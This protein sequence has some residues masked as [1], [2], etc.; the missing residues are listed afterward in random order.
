MEEFEIYPYRRVNIPPEP[1][2]G[3]AKKRHIPRIVLSKPQI[4]FWTG[5]PTILNNQKPWLMILAFVF[6][7]AL[8]LGELNPFIGPMVALIAYQCA[9]ALPGVI[10][11]ALASSFYNYH[12]VATWAG[13]VALPVIAVLI[14]LFRLNAQNHRWILPGLIFAIN[15]IAKSSIIAWLEP[16]YYNFMVVLIESLLGA[17]VVVLMTRAVPALS[18]VV[19]MRRLNFEEMACLA[20]MVGGILTG[21]NQLSWWQLSLQ[22]IV[23][24]WL[25]LMAA[26]LY[27]FGGGA[28]TGTLVGLIPSLATLAPPLL[29]GVYAFGGLMAGSCKS[30]G[31]MGVLLGFTLGNLI[32]T[33]Y[34]V[35]PNSWVGFFGETALALALFMIIPAKY[36]VSVDKYKVALA[37][38]EPGADYQEQNTSNM[39]TRFSEVFE[40]LAQTFEE[41]ATEKQVAEG[42]YWYDMMRDVGEKACAE[43]SRFQTCWERDFQRTSKYLMDCISWIELNGNISSAQLNEEFKKRCHRPREVAVAVN[44]LFATKRAHR[45]WQRDVMESREILTGQLKGLSSVMDNLAEAIVMERWRSNFQA[46]PYTIKVG[47]AKVGK[48]GSHISGDSFNTLW[49]PDG[50]AAIILSDGMGAGPEAAKE[51]SATV[52]LLS[53]LL[54][55]GMNKELAVR[56]VNSLLVMGAKD[57]T[58]AT[59][60]LVIVD[61]NSALAEFVKIGA[62]ASFIKRGSKIGIIK[63][64][65]WPIGILHTVEFEVVTQQ[66]RPGDLLIM[67]TDGVAESRIG[68]E[69]EEWILDFLETTPETK[70]QRIADSLLEYIRTQDHKAN[71]DDMTVLVIA[72]SQHTAPFH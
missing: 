1:S 57:E 36:L 7:R 50:K 37:N 38:G 11:V 5:F 19:R 21:L 56:T 60:D 25:I 54:E 40:Q 42:S 22:G 17:G 14:P 62:A 71:Q 47:V 48:E 63:S 30:F 27:G 13:M 45:Q 55:S 66:L 49:I 34:L 10:L 51:S 32:L 33:V 59:V 52:E 58:F 64:N 70:P 69:R 18:K 6:S 12:G 61:L 3:P 16:T 23:G 43:C 4:Q 44:C 2:S 46:C 31:R 20:V 67:V 35:S 8:F 53:S 24:R 9:G 68:S 26:Y 39:L 72:F 28:A 41:M 29:A 65:S 15:M